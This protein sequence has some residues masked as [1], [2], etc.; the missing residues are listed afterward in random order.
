MIEARVTGAQPAEAEGVVELGSDAWMALHLL[1]RVVVGVEE[2][3]RLEQVED[4]VRRMG[5]ALSAVT[6]ERDAL[7]Q[8]AQAASV[9]LCNASEWICREVE[10]GT[11]SAT[12]WSIR[13][14][15]NAALLRAAMAAKEGV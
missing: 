9:A 8:A 7:E 14:N 1:D 2:E 3:P 6:A 11:K 10:A 15:E 13:L 5:A 4:I 12:F